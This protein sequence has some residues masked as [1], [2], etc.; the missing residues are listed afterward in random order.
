MWQ[1]VGKVAPRHDLAFCPLVRAP[2]MLAMETKAETQQHP[3]HMIKP[4]SFTP[5]PGLQV[6]RGLQMLMALLSPQ[7]GSWQVQFS[8]AG[9]T[10]GVWVVVVPGVQAAQVAASCRAP[11]VA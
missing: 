2:S 7:L 3:V 11:W 5:A 9:N 1:P 8:R 4:I 10:A 6:G